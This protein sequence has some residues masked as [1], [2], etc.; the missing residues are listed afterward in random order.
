MNGYES[1]KSGG[2][3]C[4]VKLQSNMSVGGR[5]W[6]RWGGGTG[7]MLCVHVLGRL[8][9]CVCV[10]ERE[11]ECVCVC[12]WMCIWGWIISFRKH[13]KVL[14]CHTANLEFIVLNTNPKANELTVC[15][16]C[17]AGHCGLTVWICYISWEH[18]CVN[19]GRYYS[20]YR[21]LYSIQWA[22]TDAE[23]KD[24]SA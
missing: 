14:D 23:I 5:G 2:S 16:L 4:R 9:V 1:E 7:I 20:E 18:V 13:S 11:R 19:N 17:H 21:P 22:P 8:C 12:V 24:P 15:T 6:A 3:L 10:W